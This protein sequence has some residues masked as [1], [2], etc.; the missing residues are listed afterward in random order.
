MKK[1]IQMREPASYPDQDSKEGEDLDDKK[2]KLNVHNKIYPSTDCD[3]GKKDVHKIQP[4]T[5]DEMMGSKDDIKGK[6]RITD[7][8]QD[9]QE[10]EIKHSGKK[11][12]RMGTAFGQAVVNTPGPAMVQSADN[13][14]PS[15]NRQQSMQ[16]QLIMQQMASMNAMIQNMSSQG[17]MG[18]E[19]M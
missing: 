6:S 7:S 19:Q 5:D 3:D 2:G 14:L 4:L 12:D 18:P 1:K 15:L 16:Q 13:T 17:N 9:M 11:E 10:T 8:L